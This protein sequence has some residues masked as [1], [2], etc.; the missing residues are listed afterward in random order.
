MLLAM[1]LWGMAWASG[2]VVGTYS[3]IPI[4]VFWRFLL[5][6][7]AM[8]LILRL[9]KL[10]V[11]PPWKSLIYPLLGGVFILSYN[12]FFFIGTRKGLAGAGGILVTT[13]NPIMTFVL[14]AIIFKESIRQKDMIGL[15][16]GFVGGSIMIHI[17]TMS[18]SD[19]AMSGNA[20]FL[21]AAFSWAFVTLVSG[22]SKNAIHPLTFSFWAYLCVTI[23]VLPFSLQYPLMDIFTLDSTF[24]IHFFIL[25]LGALA[26]GTSIFFIGTAHLGSDKTSAFIFTVPVSA[27]GFSMIVLGEQLTWN[28]LSGAVFLMTAVYLISIKK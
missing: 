15:L 17:W 18:L 9:M 10:P 4:I 19:I 23:V 3:S 22:R 1:V 13:L 16:L 6:S 7:I 21:M 25:S 14:S 26:I 27:M 28:T 2:K 20:A 8:I 11:L 12:V 24:W 5:A